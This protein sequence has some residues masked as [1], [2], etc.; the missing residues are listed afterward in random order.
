V[1]LL[2][3]A[4]IAVAIKLTSRGPVPLVQVR[5]GKNGEDFPSLRF[6]IMVKRDTCNVR[7]CWARQRTRWR[8]V[9]EQIHA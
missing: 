1:R 7:T 2:L 3:I 9:T 6:P 8:D 4:F 5:I